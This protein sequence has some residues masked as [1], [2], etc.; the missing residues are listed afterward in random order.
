MKLT[1]FLISSIVAL[2]TLNSCSDVLDIAPDG[3]LSMEEVYSDPDKVGA[4]LNACYN[5]IPQK[6]YVYWFFDPLLT[7][8]SDEGW[9]SEEVQGTSVDQMYKGNASASSHPIRDMNDGHGSSNNAY[10]TRYW[11]QIRLCNQFLEN[12]G[13]AAVNDEAERA[14]FTAE[15]HVLRAYFYS[16]LIKW[17]GKVPILDKTVSFDADFSTLKRESVYDVVKFIAEDCDAAISSSELPWRITTDDEALRATKALAWAIKSKMMLFAAS[18]LFNEGKDY[19][20]EAYQMN[21]KAV[22]ELKKNGY[23]LFTTCT[24]PS[25]FGTYDAAAFHQLACQSADYSAE[26]RDKETIW[27]HRSGSVFVW[28]VGYIG[29][30]MDGTYKCGTCPTQELVDAFETTDGQPIL[31]LAK[32]YLDE[33]HLQP[34]YNPNNKMYDPENPYKNRDPRLTASVLCNGD[35]LIWNNGEVFKVET[36]VGGRHGIVLDPSERWFSRTGYYHRKLVTP[37]ASNTNPINNSNWK[38]F[39]LGEIILNYA[40]AAAE[41]GHLAEAKAAVDEIRARVK[42]PA[43]PAGL[44]KEEMILRVH[45]ERRVELAWEEVR[46]FDLRR[47]QKPEG[48]LNET[49]QWLTGMR[50]TKNNDGSFSYQRYNITS[51]PRGGYQNRDLLLPLPLDEVS[52]LESTTGLPWQNPGW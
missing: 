28:H 9:S 19:W 38:F 15:A 47:W 23:E 34:N 21:K 12:I 14:R 27:Q 20:E 26:P 52:R 49:C 10:W 37:Q 17:F 16:E 51:N 42:M 33:K 13:T 18:P 46:Y 1:Y 5:N 45:N 25:T 44:S 43:L 39:R 30:G 24:N 35:S 41:A 50:I 48:N 36:Y 31:N 8:C 6:G 29:S 2:G 4:L 3:T 40:E 7:A 22:E 11:Q 32:P